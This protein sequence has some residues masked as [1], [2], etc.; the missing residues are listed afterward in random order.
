MKQ[1][2]TLSLVFCICI[3]CFSQTKIIGNLKTEKGSPISGASVTIAKLNT[4]TIL[5]YA[6]SNTIGGFSISINSKIVE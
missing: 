5:N 2:L 1:I 3:S 4:D 6:I